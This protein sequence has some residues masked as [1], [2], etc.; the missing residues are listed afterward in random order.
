MPQPPLFLINTGH[1]KGEPLELW[2]HGAQLSPGLE[3]RGNSI[4][5]E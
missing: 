2:R 1:G 5:E 4:L 3:G